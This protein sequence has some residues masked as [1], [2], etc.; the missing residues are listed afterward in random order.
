MIT[1]LYLLFIQYVCWHPVHA[2]YNKDVTCVIDQG[3]D[4]VCKVSERVRRRNNLET[5]PSHDPYIPRNA[6]ILYN[7]TTECTLMKATSMIDIISPKLF[8]KSCFIEFSKNDDYNCDHIRYHHFKNA[9]KLL[10]LRNQIPNKSHYLVDCLVY[11]D[12]GRVCHKN[13]GSGASYTGLVDTGTIVRPNSTNILSQDEFICEE[14]EAKHIYCDLNKYVPFD[15]GLKE[16]QKVKMDDSVILKTSSW[17]VVLQR[18]CIDS[19]CGY[20]GKISSSR[21]H[22]YSPPG[23]KVYR[24]FYAEGQQICKEIGSPGRFVYNKR[25]WLD[26]RR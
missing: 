18:S 25:G 5:V 1:L 21:R 26:A 14:D 2:V 6:S 3:L 7:C 24:C 9:D 8:L 11:V 20:N 19:W 23:G 22:A 13:D 15:D 16:K 10:F 12:G 4:P 17:V